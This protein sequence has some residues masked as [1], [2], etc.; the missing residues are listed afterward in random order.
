M[1]DERAT[2][3]HPE[4]VELMLLTV[5][6]AVSIW[7][8]I[9]GDRLTPDEYQEMCASGTLQ[10]KGVK[11]MTQGGPSLFTDVDSL[12]AYLQ[13]DIR[14]QYLRVKAAVEERRLELEGC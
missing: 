10:E 2:H 14:E 3:S 9:T 8:V 1:G 11:V 13:R 12:L 7:N 5:I 4:P 6:E